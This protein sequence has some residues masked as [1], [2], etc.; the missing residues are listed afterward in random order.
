MKRP[1]WITEDGNLDLSKFPI[2]GILAQALRKTEKDSR[3]AVLDA[4]GIGRS[5][6]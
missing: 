3:R 6:V 5:G 1:A 4:V 2:D